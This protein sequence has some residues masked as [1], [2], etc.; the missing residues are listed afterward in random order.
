MALSQATE[1]IKYIEK[2][3]KQDIVS[4][5]EKDILVQSKN[6]EEAKKK[7]EK[8]L[9]TKNIPFK[10]ASKTSKSKTIDVLT[11]SNFDI[12][13]KPIRVKG[14]GGRDFEKQLTEDL[15]NYFNGDEIDNLTHGDAITELVKEI[16]L[17]PTNNLYADDSAAKKNQKR[18]LTFDDNKITISNSTGETIQ[19]VTIKPLSLYLSLKISKT[20]YT[21]NA[22][23]G[24]YFSDK[25]TKVSIN[26]F[27]GFN[28][29]EMIGFGAEYSCETPKPDYTKVGK[30][31]A[32]VLAQSVGT[33]VI[34]VHKKETN[35]VYV[36]K[37]DNTN[38]VTIN[39]LND[40]S[41]SYPI[42]SKRKGA[43]I[44]FIASINGKFYKV[45]FQFR[46]SEAHHVGPKY[47]RILLER[48]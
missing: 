7:V 32:S 33:N 1:Y 13:F 37:I 22:A 35:N 29:K 43:I 6:R 3:L 20:Y 12:V 11:V 21:L 4:M 45:D 24:H 46:G 44:K 40:A 10:S 30:N 31:L 34:L 26:T 27:F 48:I 14:Q 8:L 5:K 41:Y 2:E 47:L 42:P 15:N 39:A 25:T 16:K 19:D 38:N 18:A 9:R 23:I 17:T 36:K 28:G